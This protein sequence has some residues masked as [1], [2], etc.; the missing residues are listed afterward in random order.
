M[1]VDQLSK[2]D[3]TMIRPPHSFGGERLLELQQSRQLLGSHQLDRDRLLIEVDHDFGPAS[4][5]PTEVG[6]P[7]LVLSPRHS[8]RSGST[9]AMPEN[10]D[11]QVGA[12][13]LQNLID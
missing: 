4:R 6:L 7:K 13:D 9:E 3:F 10:S 5:L 2:I 1:R 8:V 11:K 12:L